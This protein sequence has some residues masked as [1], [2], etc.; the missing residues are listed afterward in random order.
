[1]RSER[2]RNGNTVRFAPEIMVMD[3][4]Q[5]GDLEGG[6][7]LTTIRAILLDPVSKTGWF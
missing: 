5:S 6:K 7:G 2:I 1:M 4:C 3:L